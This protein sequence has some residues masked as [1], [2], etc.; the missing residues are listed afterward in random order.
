MVVQGS[1]KQ[2]KCSLG[3]C[4][5]AGRQFSEINAQQCSC[6]VTWGPDDQIFKELPNFSLEQLHWPTSYML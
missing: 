2:S 4:V 1:S 5:V 6:Q 3:F